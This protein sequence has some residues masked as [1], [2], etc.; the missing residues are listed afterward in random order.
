MD[1][2]ELLAALTDVAEILGRRG[3]SGRVYIAVGAA[4]ALTYDSRRVTRDIDGLILEGQ[5]SR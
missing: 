1:R 2:S 5:D 3:V 4:M